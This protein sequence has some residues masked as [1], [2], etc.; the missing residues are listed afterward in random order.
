[1]DFLYNRK[2]TAIIYNDIE[3]T[4]AQF[5]NGAKYYGSLLNIEKDDRVAIFTENR[6]EFIYAFFAIWD[7]EGIAVNLDAGYTPEQLAYTLKDSCPKYMFT[8]ETNYEIAL[9]AKRIS[10]S[11]MEII[12]FE[13]QNIPES[14]AGEDAVIKSPEDDKTVVILYTSGTTG[15]PKGV[16][17]SFGNLMSNMKAIKEL[18][19]INEEDRLLAILPYHHVLPLISNLMMPIYFGSLVVILKELS[20]EALKAALAKYKITVVMGVPRI[21]EMFHKGIMGKINSSKLTSTLFRICEKIE[22][23]ALSKL[24]F[25][26]VQEAF[27]GN[28]KALA[29]GGAK[30]DTQIAKDFTT[31]GFMVVEGY[32]LTETSPIISFNRPG[33]IKAGTVGTPISGVEVRIGED[34]EILARGQ[35][36]MKGYYNKPQATAEVID[37]EGWF[38]TGD[39]GYFDGEHLVISGRKKEM[40][41]LSNG[42]NINPGDIE[43]E[44]LKGTELIKEVAII[45]HN[46][47]LMAL[48]FPDFQLAKEK[49]I[50]N[51]RESLKWEIIDKYNVT[52]PKYR[53]I[54]ETKIVTE[55]LP[56]TRLGKL[57]RFKLSA[58]LEGHES[59][60]GTG[61]TEK[62]VIKKS[63]YVENSEYLKIKE[64]LEKLHGDV[65]INPD[66]HTEI[67]IGMDS[68]D[69]VE[70][71]AFIETTFGIQ[72]S[73]E[74]LAKAKLV[75][76]IAD[77]VRTKGGEFREADVDWQKIFN[78]P[79]NHPMPKSDCA[80]RMISNLI[81]KPFFSLYVKLKKSGEETIPKAPTIFVGNHQS[82]LD[83]FAF[84]QLLD[85]ETASKTYSIGISI[86]FAQKWRKWLAD[87]SNIIVIDMDKNVKETLKIAAK[88]LKEGKNIL[89]FPEGARTR[90]GELQE[91]KKSF[92]ILSK[93]LNIPVTVFGIKGA[94]ELMP[95]GKSMPS[96]GEMK[97]EVLGV[98]APENLNVEEIV[99]K[100]KEKIDEYLKI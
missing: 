8:S 64:Y 46:K 56:K 76:E 4:Y 52:A 51:I 37:S 83:A 18:G 9:E 32:G 40:I 98:I 59:G 70:L 53:K 12:K 87:R 50:V 86:H 47:H 35:N 30:L 28:I 99:K 41:V 48:I 31:L 39:M 36:I 62:K 65:E 34:G 33:N 81:L 3:Y 80:G 2:K 90:D 45:E 79:I 66:S 10:N 49:G 89:I 72:F 55:E 14:F 15:D 20:S 67:D 25:K 16:M 44:L 27:G 13:D 94:Y 17:L 54:L 100:S 95:T 19:I 5:I 75:R 1:M 23:P 43:T 57:Q 11:D 82:M 71:I 88:V 60:E 68:L 93:E 61:E 74:E 77:T 73:E 84:A 42:K 92:A 6:P 85:K 26:K 69:N 91:F 21:W 7:R 24:I 97:I 29:S 38:H 58:L 63:D 96:K 78:M 22:N